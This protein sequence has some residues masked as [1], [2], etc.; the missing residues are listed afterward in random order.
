M[1]DAGVGDPGTVSVAADV[2]R[3]MF[4]V[5]LVSAVISAAAFLDSAA[6][7][8]FV[9][10]VPLR[11]VTVGVTTFVNVG[12]VT[13]L[14]AIPAGITLGTGATPSCLGPQDRIASSPSTFGD[15]A[16]RI[17]LTKAPADLGLLL[18]ANSPRI[19]PTHDLSICPTIRVD[20]LT[21][22]EVHSFDLLPSVPQTSGAL[23]PLPDSAPI[24]GRTFH[25]QATNARPAATCVPSCFGLRASNTLSMTLLAPSSTSGIEWD[26]GAPRRPRGEVRRFSI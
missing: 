12:R 15:S 24:V 8:G 22:A 23:P 5:F 17:N 2:D 10:D 20:P 21:V 16:F 3:D 18:F 26:R 13:A 6:A 11:N 19:A 14:S 7:L 9:V 1:E 25:G 4:P